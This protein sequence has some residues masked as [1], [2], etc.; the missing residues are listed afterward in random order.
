MV[1]NIDKLSDQDVYDK[2]LDQAYPLEDEFKRI[3]QEEPAKLMDAVFQ[4]KRKLLVGRFMQKLTGDASKLTNDANN[5]CNERIKTYAEKRYGIIVNQ[6]VA[7]KLNQKNEEQLVLL[8]EQVTVLS[9]YL[10]HVDNNFT[11]MITYMG[12]FMRSQ[13]VDRFPGLYSFLSKVNSPSSVYYN[14]DVDTE[15]RIGYNN[16]SIKKTQQFML[17]QIL[18]A[19]GLLHQS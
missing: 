18:E 15:D 3:L 6:D 10:T 1:G 2:F 12:A 17:H 13:F 16:E 19:A 5:N 14:N 4:F 8:Q 11:E 7:E 9:S